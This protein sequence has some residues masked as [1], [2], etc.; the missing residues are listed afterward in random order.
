MI[1]LANAFSL[2]MLVMDDWG[3]TVH[4]VPLTG[5][6]TRRLLRQGFVSA[7]GHPDTARLLSDLVETPVPFNRI[8]VALGE[9]DTLIVAQYQGPR[10]EEGATRLPMG[11]GFRF[12]QVTYQR[13]TPRPAHDPGHVDDSILGFSE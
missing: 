5:D 10:L 7:V 11:A 6:D 2:Q 13:V 12:Y 9:G 4:V 8:S 3:A 1:Y